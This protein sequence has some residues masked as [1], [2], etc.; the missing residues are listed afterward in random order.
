[1]IKNINT[2]NLCNQ[3]SIAEIRDCCKRQQS[4]RGNKKEGV[5]IEVHPLFYKTLNYRRDF[6][7]FDT[8]KAIFFLAGI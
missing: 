3:V 7:S 8:L 4:P 2:F 1:M 6:S 5:P